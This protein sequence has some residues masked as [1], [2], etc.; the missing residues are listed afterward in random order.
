MIDKL[1]QSIV[2][3]TDFSPAGLDAFVHALR[4]AVAAEGCFY[5]LHI[6][7]ETERA[8]WVRFPRVRETLATWG[9]IAPDAPRSAVASEL[10]LRVE[11]TI[12]GSDDP[13]LGV[14]SFVERHQCD[15]LVLFTHARAAPQRWFHRSIAE[16]TA[17]QS[18]AA[19]LFLREGQRGFVDR[20]TGAISLQRILLPVDGSL[21]Y[22]YAYQWIETFERLAGSSCRVQPLHVGLSIPR[23]ANELEGTIEVREGPVVETIISVAE[24]I[25]AKIIVMPTA[26]HHGLLD[27]LRGSVTERVL[28]E[29]PCPVLAVPVM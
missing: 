1:V 18:H 13:V 16:A 2:H 8:D 20:D 11:K 23:N 14:E 28:R 19:S 17:R 7:G 27:A 21:P 6:E 12:I 26:G 3:P 10:G 4:L 15:L 24:E 29:A 25:D 5:I 22:Q 9:M